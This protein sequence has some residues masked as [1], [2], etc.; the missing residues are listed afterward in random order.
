VNVRRRYIA[1]L[2]LCAALAVHIT[3]EALTGFL[4]L[5]NPAVLSIRERVPW[6][7]FPTFAFGL[8]IT[9]L[10]LAVVGFL[11]LSPWVARGLPWT[12]HA[13]R[14]F[15]AL[16]LANGIAHLGFSIYKKTWMSG[17]YT[18]P[19]LVAASVYLLASARRPAYSSE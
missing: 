7:I 12:L 17:S 18:S 9:L 19:L 5:Y 11:I 16:M 3:D 4:D 1:W 8:W 13:S 2:L 15:G 10:G 6:L 14:I